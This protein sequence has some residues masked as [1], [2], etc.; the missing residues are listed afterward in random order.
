MTLAPAWFSGGGRAAPEGRWGRTANTGAVPGREGPHP[1]PTRG[2][3]G[4]VQE[5]LPARGFKLRLPGSRQRH[6][7]VF[8]PS[9][10]QMR[11]LRPREVE[12]GHPES[13]H[14]KAEFTRGPRSFQNPSENPHTLLGGGFHYPVR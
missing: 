14:V 7:T 11:K 10:W 2:Q 3:E 8:S 5:G 12:R 13:R 1:P 9:V 4:G 6:D